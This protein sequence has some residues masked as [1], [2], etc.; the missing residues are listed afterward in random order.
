MGNECITKPMG[1]PMSNTT[2]L[3]NVDAERVNAVMQE[4]EENSSYFENTSLRVV[5][6][7]T[8]SLDDLMKAIY[9]DVII[10]DYPSELTLEKYFLELTNTVYFM[11]EK[12]ESLG[13]RDDMSRA[14]YK[15]VYNAAYLG[16]QIKD[17]EKKN[18]T[19]VAE[20]QAVAENAALYENTVNSIYNRA[21]KIF[22]YKIDAANEMIRSLSK[23]ISRRMQE[24]SLNERNYY[25]ETGV[26]GTNNGQ[27]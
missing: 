13:V 27:I 4:T 18:K 26:G 12:L 24:S 1:R 7:Y 9:Q 23:I 19:T 14:Q 21:Y 2:F 17:V 3:N 22:K 10:V 6:S 15:E 11:G 16:N 5:E 25:N 20:N 8:Q